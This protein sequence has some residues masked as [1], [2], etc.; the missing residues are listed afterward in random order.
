MLRNPMKHPTTRAPAITNFF[1]EP[2]F[3]VVVSVVTSNVE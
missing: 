1:R 2:D 3:G